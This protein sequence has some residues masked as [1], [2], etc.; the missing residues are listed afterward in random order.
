MSHYPLQ[1]SFYH[2]VVRRWC[3]GATPLPQP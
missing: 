2:L 3:S 1:V